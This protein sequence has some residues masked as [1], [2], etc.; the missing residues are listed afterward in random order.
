MPSSA[1]E[2]AKGKYKLVLRKGKKIRHSGRSVS[3][4]VP[5]GSTGPLD[6][7]FSYASRRGDCRVGV[8]VRSLGGAWRRGRREGARSKETIPSGEADAV[9]ADLPE[10]MRVHDLSVLLVAAP[11]QSYLWGRRREPRLGRRWKPW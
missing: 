4:V 2:I 5:M 10:V 8:C 6:G 9:A 11:R 3:R 1:M 7:C